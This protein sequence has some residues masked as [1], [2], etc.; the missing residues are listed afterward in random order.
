MINL[1]WKDL[2]ILKRI[3]LIAPIFAIYG[4]FIFSFTMKGGALIFITILVTYTLL[5]RACDLDARNKSEI[6]MNS[7]PV[8]R[9]DIVLA[10]YLSVFPYAAIAILSS[11]FA[12]EVMSVTGISVLGGAPISQISL[13]GFVGALVS[14]VT[15]ISFYY[16]IYFKLG[17][18]RIKWLGMILVLS[19]MFFIPMGS[20]MARR[21]GEVSNPILQ[22]ILVLMG[23]LGNWLQTQA[24]WQIASYMLVLAL[25]LMSASVRLSMR[26]YARR[27]F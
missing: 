18:A 27:E 20:N 1:V 19:L 15:F 5:D 8:S 17:Y 13:E 11:L 3:L 6:I 23:R 21:L 7:L 25:I 2:Q 9:R 16:P 14:M 4:F 10:K 26:F 24:D 12:Q 22:K